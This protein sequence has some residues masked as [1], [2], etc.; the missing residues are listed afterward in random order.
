MLCQPILFCNWSPSQAKNN[1]NAHL[2]LAYII[3]TFLHPQ[4]IILYQDLV[5]SGSVVHHSPN[6][7]SDM[8]VELC[9]VEQHIVSNKVLSR[10]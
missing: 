2:G 6:T 3:I 10:K 4:D 8:V 5:A 9:R 7:T 1:V